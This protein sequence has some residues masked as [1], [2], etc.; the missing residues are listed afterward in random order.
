MITADKARE[1]S[2]DLPLPYYLRDI[3]TQI[4][5]NASLGMYGTQRDY[6][7][8]DKLRDK[9]VSALTDSGY[10]VRCRKT[11]RNSVVLNIDWMPV[12]S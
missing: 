3:E 11:D 8:D 4:I 10:S 7:I 12:T 6:T 2:R 5:H 1:Y 9:I